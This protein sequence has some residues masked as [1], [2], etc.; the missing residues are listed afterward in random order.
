MPAAHSLP[1]S[2]HLR[3]SSTSARSFDLRGL[4]SN[5]RIRSSSS[6]LVSL[7]HISPSHGAAVERNLLLF[8]QITSVSFSAA[9]PL[10]C[11]PTITAATTLCYKH[12]KSAGTSLHQKSREI[13]P[14]DRHFL[15]LLVV[16]PGISSETLFATCEIRQELQM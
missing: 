12:D 11:V 8:I 16:I 9:G 7:S 3:T 4:C 1:H 2:H 13:P 15:L 5:H 10:L 14:T 6:C